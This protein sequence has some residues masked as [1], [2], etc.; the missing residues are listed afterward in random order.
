[1]FD[2]TNLDIQGFTVF[3]TI[4]KELFRYF[5]TNDNNIIHTVSNIMVLLSTI[6]MWVHTKCIQRT[7]RLPISSSD[8][9]S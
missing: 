9:S 3:I 7:Q 6:T 2:F 4:T 8:K 1:M 5:A